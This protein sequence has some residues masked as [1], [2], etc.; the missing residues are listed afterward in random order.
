MDPPPP[1]LTSGPTGAAMARVELE[2][3]L[4]HLHPAAFGWALA[5]CGGDRSAAEDALQATYL[6]IL[7]GRARFEG[8]SSFRTWVFGVLRRTASEER[9]GGRGWSWG[10]LSLLASHPATGSDRHHADAGVLR[11]EESSRLLAALQALPARQREVLHLVFY[12]DLTI[13]EAAEVAGV[14]LGTA[15]THYA[16]GKAALRRLLEEL[17]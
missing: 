12:Q 13:A 1:P 17:R 16:R 2:Q 10:P 15:R 3:E 8:R 11:S 14:G 9:R 5:C 6:K 7:D 4:E